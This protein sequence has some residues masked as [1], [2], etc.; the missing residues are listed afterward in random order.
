MEIK[1]NL[2]KR[3]SK[4]FK[5][6]VVTMYI[7]SNESLRSLSANLGVSLVSIWKWI[8]NFAKENPDDTRLMDK[9]RAN[10]T[11]YG[12]KKPND[13][14][15]EARSK[16]VV[17]SQPDTTDG[18]SSLSAE[19][20]LRMLKIQLQKERLRADAYEEM[21]SVAESKF[22]INIRKKAGAKQ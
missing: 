7:E 15:E 1:G 16:E 18:T 2:G 4:S 5:N 22:N 14:V 6:E 8:S 9:I 21:I 3:Y 17:V 11:N 19:E 10:S 13:G 12:P 20:E